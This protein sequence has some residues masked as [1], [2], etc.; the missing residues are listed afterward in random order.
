MWSSWFGNTPEQPTVITSPPKDVVYLIEGTLRV[1]LDLPNHAKRDFRA[2]RQWVFDSIARL[3]LEENV[4]YYTFKVLPNDYV[5]WYSLY[6]SKTNDSQGI[7]MKYDA[8]LGAFIGITDPDE[9]LPQIQVPK[10][11]VVQEDK[12]I[13]EHEDNNNK[14]CEIIISQTAINT[15]RLPSKR[16]RTRK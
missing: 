7:L 14:A 6:E 11:E 15:K 12:S 8:A 13:A 4:E 1:P 9:E 5:Y 10:E 2:I 3:P 16:N